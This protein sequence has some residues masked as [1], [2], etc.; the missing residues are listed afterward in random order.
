MF[1]FYFL[2]QSVKH[3]NWADVSPT[4]MKKIDYRNTKVK[5]HAFLLKQ[6]RKEKIEEPFQT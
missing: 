2:V 5:L 3:F 1:L 6:N 4:W